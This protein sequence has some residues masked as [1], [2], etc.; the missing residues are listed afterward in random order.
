MLKQ[1]GH[2]VNLILGSRSDIK[3]S[4]ISSSDLIAIST[5]TSTVIEAYHLADFARSQGKKV[6]MGGAHVSFMAEEALE[7]CDYVCRGEA[8]LTFTDLVACIE[9][10]ELPWAVPGVSFKTAEG[11]VHNPRPDW[12]DINQVPFP[13]FSLL[14]SLKMSTYPVMT[15]R[16]CPFDCTFC[17]VTSMFG[18]KYRYRETESIL[19][20]LQQYKGK[21]VFFIDDNFAA[22]PRHTKEL[23]K[24]M[25]ARKTLP[26]WWCAQVRTDAARDDELLALMRDSNCG[27]VFVGM[28]SVNPQTLKTYN[29]KQGVADIEY[30]IKRFHEYGIML[31]GMFVFGSDDD[32]AETI[33]DTLEFALRNR[34]DSVQFMIL[35][36]L[37]GS[38]T[39]KEL[40][41]QGRIL[42]R[43]WNLYDAHHVVFQ[44]RLM[45]AYELQVKS[46]EAFKK[47]YSFPNIFGN[48][49]LTG[50]RSA[51]FRALGFW[52]IRKWLRDNRWFYIYL[53]SLSAPVQTLGWKSRI[54]K[55]IE[56]FQLRKLKYFATEKLI[57]IEI[58][59]QEETFVL[60]LKGYLN[61]FSLGETFKT[62]YNNVPGMYQNFL[63]N[64]EEVSFAS[65]KVLI[66][67]IEK[68]NNLAQ[69]ARQVEIKTALSRESISV[70]LK[71][72]DLKL[73][74]FNIN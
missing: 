57:H 49:F 8:D 50:I 6:I 37:P 32:T 4:H 13:D 70:V 58:S 48:L 23:L 72:Y 11:V 39:F 45:S 26:S 36:P 54:S 56:T 42:T 24:E 34:I 29:K 3:L 22:N 30:C 44:P 74:S 66:R 1:K 52:M 65:E 27:T 61:D 33:D 38:R 51:A 31:H 15:S 69:R 18:R 21:Q 17:S 46:M 63:I 60:N 47:F 20:E 25:I 28:E 67:F 19:E 68:L 7:H 64:I 53:N 41:E 35:T 59:Q 10:D 62:L 12:V 14:S 43:D 16:G 40:E 9:R 73:P 71:K 5:T 2:E 55:S